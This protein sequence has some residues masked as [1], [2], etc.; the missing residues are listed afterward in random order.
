MPLRSDP[1]LTQSFSQTHCPACSSTSRRLSRRARPAHD[2]R[3]LRLPTSPACPPPSRSARC[4]LRRGALLFR[5]R[6][7]FWPRCRVCSRRP[8]HCVTLRIDRTL[9]DSLRHGAIWSYLWQ[10]IARP[11]VG[12]RCTP[13]PEVVSC[14]SEYGSRLKALELSLEGILHEVRPCPTHPW[15]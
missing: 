14:A 11:R 6:Q 10:A 2:S 4:A 9:Y 12:C 7:Q 3:I 1:P 5:A 15:P 8:L 13:A